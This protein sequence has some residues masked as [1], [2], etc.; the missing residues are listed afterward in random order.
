LALL[1]GRADKP[2]GLEMLIGFLAWSG[3]LGIER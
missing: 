2:H 3:V 1:I